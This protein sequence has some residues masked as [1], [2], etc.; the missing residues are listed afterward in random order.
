MKHDFKNLGA[1]TQVVVALSLTLA[2]IGTA[3][4]QEDGPTIAKDSIRV[5]IENNA[6][7]TNT[8]QT[9]AWLPSIAFRVNGPIPKASQ[10]NVQF[11]LPTKKKWLEFDC[12][13]AEIKK[14][15]WWKTSCSGGGKPNAVFYS[16]PMDFV[17][18]IRNEVFGTDATLFTGK[19]K[20]MKRPQFAGSKE[21]E[22]YVDED[23]NMPI[24]YV[25]FDNSPGH[26]S[27]FLFAGFWFRGNPPDIEAHLLFNGNII[28]TFNR[29]GNGAG[30]WDPAAPMWGF[31]ACYFL[32]VYRTEEEAQNGYD[33]KFSIEKNPGEYEV[34]VLIVNKLARSIKFSVDAN[35]LVD[36]GIA[37]NNQLGTDRIIVPVKV[38]GDQGPWDKLAWKAGAFYGNPLTGFAAIP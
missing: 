21:F 26:G 23:W 25:Y 22:Y 5:T 1:L 14:G 30:S 36:N 16:G 35:G 3:A 19:A 34:R 27:T 18:K 28:G 13:T 6:G 10:L 9:S 4:A 17:I 8:S 12:D 31:Q 15:E 7:G 20:V 32:G 37:K 29:A 38:I 33:P 2:A 11:S 24:G